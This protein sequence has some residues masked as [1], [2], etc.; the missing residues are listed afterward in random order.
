MTNDTQDGKYDA[1]RGPTGDGSRDAS[2]EGPMDDES[3]SCFVIGPMGGG[4]MTRLRRLATDVIQPLVRQH[5]FEVQTPDHA[6]VGRIMDQVLLSLDQAELLV[7]DLTGNNPNVLY[8]LAVY[9][10]TGRPYVTVRDTARALDGERTP[11]DIQAYRY[12]EINLDDPAEAR[13]QLA[14]VIERLFARG[15]RRNWYSNPIT[16]F[17]QNPATHLRYATAMAEN[18]I[19]NF[20]RKVLDAVFEQQ[21]RVTV[22][23]AEVPAGQPRRIDILLPSD[24]NQAR[25]RFIERRLLE[26]GHLVRASIATATRNITLYADPRSKPVCR[27]VDVPTILAT[28]RASVEQRMGPQA[29]QGRIDRRLRARMERLEAKRFRAE[30]GVE[31]ERI[32]DER[33]YTPDHIRI[34]EGVPLGPEGPSDTGRDAAAL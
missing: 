31:L 30:L 26:P 11:F 3:R 32:M 10:M 22:A 28:L 14:P 24:F 13:E 7:A 20:I 2:E 27:L 9:H 18:Y 8:E 23:G 16:D 4:Q 19:R 5:G 12:V 21:A 29:R 15:N 34:V 17:Y 1:G 33:M 25:H 6:D